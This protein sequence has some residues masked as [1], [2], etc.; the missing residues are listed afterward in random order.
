MKLTAVITL[1]V[2]VFLGASYCLAAGASV[3]PQEAG[4][5]LTRR[6]YNL[7]TFTPAA[8]YICREFRLAKTLIFLG[9]GN[10]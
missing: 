4:D 9:G 1:A 2:S 3:G 10:V 8:L 5:R 7:L 6:R